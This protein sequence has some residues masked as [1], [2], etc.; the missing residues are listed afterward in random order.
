MPIAGRSS[1]TCARRRA[2]ADRAMV[3]APHPPAAPRL[4]LVR[5]SAALSLFFFS[6]CYEGPD[7]P[8]GQPWYGNDESSGD[9]G[10]D[11][12]PAGDDESGGADAAADDAAADDAPADDG[13]PMDDG[14]VDDGS[15]DD[16]SV[17]DGSV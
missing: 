10:D 14:S 2:Y 15:V 13:P 11:D 3:P 9:D 5:L 6:G 12:A 16:G 4:H 17:D 8:D 7:F 1:S